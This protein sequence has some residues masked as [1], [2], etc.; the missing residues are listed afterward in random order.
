MFCGRLYLQ[1][2]TEVIY[3]EMDDRY[4]VSNARL[5]YPWLANHHIGPIE[6]TTASQDTPIYGANRQLFPR[7]GGNPINELLPVTISQSGLLYRLS[8]LETSI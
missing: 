5:L 7:C 6:P 2:V 8:V 4:T 1:E 3:V